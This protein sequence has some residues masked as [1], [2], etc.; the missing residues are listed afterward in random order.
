MKKVS[1][2]ETEA[3]AF[4]KSVLPSIPDPRERQRIKEAVQKIAAA[5]EKHIQE[6]QG[7][8][9]SAREEKEWNGS[10]NSATRIVTCL[11]PL[12]SGL[13]LSTCFVSAER[14]LKT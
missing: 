3:K 14:A 9:D 7:E 1:I 4:F 13:A 5:A 8:L 12:G 6:L 2:L 10:Q 11:N